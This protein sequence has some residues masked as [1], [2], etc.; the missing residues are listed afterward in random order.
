M[1]VSLARNDGEKHSRRVHRTV[2]SS[3]IRR[4]TINL[5]GGGV[6][7]AYDRLLTSLAVR[8]RETGGTS[9]AVAIDRIGTTSTI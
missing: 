7:V 1:R 3:S 9:T 5:H 2:T 4:S 6:G 8:A